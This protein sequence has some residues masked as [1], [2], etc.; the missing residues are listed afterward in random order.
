MKMKNINLFRFGVVYTFFSVFS[1][2]SCVPTCPPYTINVGI[3][4]T[5][6]TTLKTI[7]C[8]TLTGT[9]AYSIDT[10]SDGYSY[11]AIDSSSGIL[12]LANLLDVEYG[13][14]TWTVNVMATDDTGTTTT[15]VTV[16]TYIS[17]TTTTSTQPPPGYDWFDE[18]HNKYLFWSVM[19][20]AAAM[21]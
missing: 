9:V 4:S 16:N 19:G 7:A 18:A 11:F 10:S 3:N 20:F 8:N 1:L 15:V 5:A 12:S 14:R 21:T 17:T 6:G 2:I 13:P